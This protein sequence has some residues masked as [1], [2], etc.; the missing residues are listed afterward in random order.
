MVLEDIPIEEL[1]AV[2]ALQGFAA[3]ED[4]PVLLQCSDAL[5]KGQLLALH[6]H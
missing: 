1:G 5:L 6:L 2:G 3:I 4:S